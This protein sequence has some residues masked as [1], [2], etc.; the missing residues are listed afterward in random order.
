MYQA[1]R[2]AIDRMTTE[3]TEV[4]GHGVVGVR[5][6]RGSFPLGGPQFKAIGTRGTRAGRGARATI[7]FTVTCPV[8]SRSDHEGAGYPRGLVLG[9][10][11]GRGTT[12]ATPP[13]RRAGGSGNAEVASWTELVNESRHDARRELESDVNDSAPTAW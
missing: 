6:S 11:I 3:C 4:G 1:R 10:S 2:S 13:A 7:P 12:T 8:G 9:I 5:L